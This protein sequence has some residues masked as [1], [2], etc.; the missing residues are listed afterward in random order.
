MS[1]GIKMGIQQI[2]CSCMVFATLSTGHCATA[3]VGKKINLPDF[4]EGAAYMLGRLSNEELVQVERSE[5]VYLALITRQGLERSVKKIAVSE[6]AAL[7]KTDRTTQIIIGIQS[8]EGADASSTVE[9]LAFLLADLPSEELGS[10]RETFAD[11]ARSGETS[12]IRSIGYA[13]M[14]LADKD[15]Q[16]AWS[17]AEA[18]ESGSTDFLVG[19]KYV[20]SPGL[21]AGYFPIVEPLLSTNTNPGILRQAIRTSPLMSGHEAEV[22]RTLTH[23]LVSGVEPDATVQALL[24]IPLTHWQRG[25]LGEMGNRVVEMATRSSALDR[26]SESFHRLLQ[27]GEEVANH[28]PASE[29]ESVRDR[30]TELGIRVVTLRVIPQVLRYDRKQILVEAGEPVEIHLKNTGIM[31]HNL[32]ITRP[33][34]LQEIGMAATEMINEPKGQEGK[35]FVPISDKVLWATPLL[36]AGE[37][38]TLTFTAPEQVGDYPFVCT[39]PGHWASMNGVMRVVSNVSKH[40]SK[41]PTTHT[42]LQQGDHA[43]HE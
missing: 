33:G 10:H 40:A 41:I 34:A 27:L 23:F 35:Q 43:G 12:K 13:A 3:F 5:P 9:D 20:V 42:G 8:I 1:N 39:F 25:S 30:L 4:P 11:F 15:V 21:R 17:L 18:S 16:P 19:A 26:N 32:V 28:L 31:P 14:V 38:T 24:Q 7:R 36:M 22:F 6:L 37:S 29:A 2:L